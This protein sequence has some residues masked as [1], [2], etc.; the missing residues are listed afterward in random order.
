MHAQPLTGERLSRRARWMKPSVL[1]LDGWSLQELRQ[2]PMRLL[3]WLAN[4]LDW[5][6]N[7]L[8]LVE[9]RGRWPSALAEGYTALIPKE[10]PP[11][12]LNTRPLTVLSMVYRLWAGARLE[13]VIVWQEGWAHPLAFGFRPA[14]GWL[15]GAAVTQVLLQLCRLKGW[16][17]SGMSI[18]Y[19]KCFDLIPQAIVL[20]VAA[21]LGL[22]AGVLRALAAMY[23]QLRRDFKVASAQGSWWRA[24]KRHPPGFPPVGHPHQSADVGVEG[25]G[26]LLGPTSGDTHAGDAADTGARGGGGAG[27]TGGR[28]DPPARRPRLRSG[29]SAGL[30]R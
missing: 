7:L 20:R 25:G 23:R 4:L 10:G 5:L 21:E 16:T 19:K 29:G 9:E 24:T 15:D 18:D 14:P 27:N 3:D 2:L 1:G 11:G 28:R 26:G 6:A 12:P 8:Q 22:D 17:V 30:R 13:E